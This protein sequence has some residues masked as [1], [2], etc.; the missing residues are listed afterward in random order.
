M[1]IQEGALLEH[2]TQYH[3]ERTREYS[4]LLAKELD[5]NHFF[6]DQIY[7]VGPLHDIGKIGIRDD[8]LLKPGKLTHEE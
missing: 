1:A 7:M 8:I 4:V 2:R 6:I 5:L 3:L